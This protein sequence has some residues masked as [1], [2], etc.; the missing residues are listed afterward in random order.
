MKQSL[1]NTDNIIMRDKTRLISLEQAIQLVMVLPGKGAKESR[2]LFAEIIKRYMIDNS[3]TTCTSPSVVGQQVSPRVTPSSIGIKRGFGEINIE[4]RG[5]DFVCKS[6]DL[7]EEALK[8]RY[9]RDMAIFKNKNKDLVQMHMENEII[10]KENNTDEGYIEK[11][12]LQINLV[13]EDL[14]DVTEEWDDMYESI[15]I[16]GEP[17]I[18][19]LEGK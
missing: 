7:Q 14:P 3:F 16:L 18:K 15:R 8:M 12:K 1:F 13:Q 9:C 2:A 5:M 17:Y 10:E 4:E 6:F 11:L 19:E